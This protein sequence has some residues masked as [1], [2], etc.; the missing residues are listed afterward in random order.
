[1]KN[2][3]T[4]K[5]DDEIAIFFGDP[6]KIRQVIQKGIHSELKKHKLAGNAIC[7]WKDNKI[8]WIPAEQ[9]NVS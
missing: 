5:V 8:H 4:N 9:I 6:E 1:M 3:T 7:E 2:N